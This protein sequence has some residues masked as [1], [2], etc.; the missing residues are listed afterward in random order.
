MVMAFDPS[1]V[2]SPRPAP[3]PVL[4][5]VVRVLAVVDA[6]VLPTML[7]VW[8]WALP[9]HHGGFFGAAIGTGVV[10]WGCRR[11]SRAIFEFE[12]YGWGTL[13]WTVGLCLVAVV[14]WCLR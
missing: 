8:V 4:D 10:L 9:D 14:F 7:M 2:R 6:L 11:A 12:R 1:R 3:F 13:R 5:V